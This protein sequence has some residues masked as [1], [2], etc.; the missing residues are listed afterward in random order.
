MASDGITVA[1]VVNQ[2]AISPFMYRPR[3][4]QYFQDR[5]IV[6]VASK[7][8]HRACGLEEGIIQSIATKH[9]VTAAQV[10]LRWGTEKGLVVVAKTSNS[11][12]MAENRGTL[13]FA[14]TRQEMTELDSLTSENEILV[15]EELEVER[16]NDG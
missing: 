4:I 15:R 2:I 16:K 7:A 10:L 14:L 8:L 9:N 6:M 3:I 5:G 12:R 1:P 11:Q 13:G